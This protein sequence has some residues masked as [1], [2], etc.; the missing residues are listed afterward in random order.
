MLAIKKTSNEK[1]SA[2]GWGQQKL[3]CLKNEEETENYQKLI[4]C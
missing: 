1:V 2:Y 4:Y 3:N